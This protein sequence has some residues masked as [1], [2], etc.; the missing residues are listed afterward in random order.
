MESISTPRISGRIINSF[1]GR[2]VIVVGKVVQIR[3]DQATLDADGNVTINVTRVSSA[4][5]GVLN[6][7]SV[8]SLRV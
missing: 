8:Y 7:H 4:V 1:V 6:S 2:N 3:G 5:Y